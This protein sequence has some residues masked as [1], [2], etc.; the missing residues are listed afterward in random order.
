MLPLLCFN[1]FNKILFR[2]ESFSKNKGHA[3]E[4]RKQTLDSNV[5]KNNFKAQYYFNIKLYLRNIKGKKT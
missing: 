4:D 3:K 1:N 5:C 2:I